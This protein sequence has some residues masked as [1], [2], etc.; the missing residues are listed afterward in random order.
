M[1]TR[2]VYQTP[3]PPA[4]LPATEPDTSYRDAI[5][6]RDIYEYFGNRVVESRA[7]NGRIVAVK[8]NPRSRSVRAEAKMMDYVSRQPGLLAPHVLGCY[9][10]ESFITVMVSDLV[11]GVSLDQA[12]HQMSAQERKSI[13][14]QLREQLRLFRTCTQNYIGR[15]DHQ[16][17]RNFYERLEKKKMGPFESEAEFDD[18]CLARI[19]SPTAH[20]IW[21]RLLPKMRGTDSKAFVLTHGDL[22]ARNIMVQDGRI[23]GIVDWEDGGFFPEYVEYALAMKICDGIED[24][25][26]PVLKEVLQPCGWKRL[27]FQAMI[28][29]RGY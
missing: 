5:I 1:K 23:T 7:S 9:N 11:P 25:W 16:P 14:A 20:S 18:W 21:K 13:K 24:W 17:T 8:V 27:K 19:K 6:G 22:A 2:H 10:V 12:W 26:V 29:N 3:P 15:L 28:K 4:A